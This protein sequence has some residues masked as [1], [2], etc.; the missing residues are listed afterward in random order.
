MYDLNDNFGDAQSSFNID[1]IED[2]MMEMVYET[3]MINV[4]DAI[5]SDTPVS[6]KLK[7]L[8]S[9]LKHF[10]NIEEYE[11]CGNIKKIIEDIKC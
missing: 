4:D 9:V 7:A 2:T 1:K 5:K 10:E 8:Y 11:K 6:E 3:I